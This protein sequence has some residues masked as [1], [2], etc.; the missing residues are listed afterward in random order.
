MDPFQKHIS[1]LRRLYEEEGMTAMQT[2]EEMESR[3]G[4]PSTR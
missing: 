3:F 2:K 4:L 1:T